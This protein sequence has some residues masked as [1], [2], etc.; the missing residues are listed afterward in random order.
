[1]PA[2]GPERAVRL[3]E[4]FGSVRAVMTG[5]ADDLAAVN[6][7]GKRTAAKIR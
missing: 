3:L 7:I 2:V 5:W 4:R 1:L 6:G